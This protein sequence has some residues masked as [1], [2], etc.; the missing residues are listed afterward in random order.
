MQGKLKKGHRYHSVTKS[1]NG[2]NHL[3]N[4]RG[5]QPV[6]LTHGFLLTEALLALNDYTSMLVGANLFPAEP[7]HSA[8]DCT[9]VPIRCSTQ[10]SDCV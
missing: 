6:P 1:L 2:I 9:L 4:H 3:Q 7:H 10:E 5:G 8:P